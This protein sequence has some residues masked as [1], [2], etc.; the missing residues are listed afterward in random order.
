MQNISVFI[1]DTHQWSLS[2]PLYNQNRILLA[3]YRP[4]FFLSWIQRGIILPLVHTWSFN[5]AVDCLCNIYCLQYKCSLLHLLEIICYVSLTYLLQVLH[6]LVGCGFHQRKQV[7]WI[8][9]KE[10]FICLTRMGHALFPTPSFCNWQKYGYGEII[11]VV[12]FIYVF[13]I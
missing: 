5:F 9:E 4:F 10:V 6:W 13:C 7:V 2:F 3:C 8:S 1:F 12:V 11:K